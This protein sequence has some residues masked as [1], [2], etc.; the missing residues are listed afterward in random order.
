MSEL[1]LQNCLYTHIQWG[2]VLKTDTSGGTWTKEG[3]WEG[4]E[5]G[6]TDG[7]RCFPTMLQMGWESRFWPKKWNLKTV[8]LTIRCQTIARERALRKG[9]KGEKHLKEEML[10]YNVKSKK[11]QIGCCNYDRTKKEKKRRRQSLETNKIKWS[12]EYLNFNIA[13]CIC[14]YIFCNWMNNCRGCSCCH[15]S[16]V[17]ETFP[18]ENVF[19]L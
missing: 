6:W 12:M 5:A 3:Q 14:L 7:R 2:L 9:L 17:N 10:Y 1:G 11:K 18:S 16:R 8:T 13:L 4:E 19:D 15:E